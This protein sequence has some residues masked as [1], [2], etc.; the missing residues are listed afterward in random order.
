ML[1]AVTVILASCGS[2]GSASPTTVAATTATTS[3]AES[4][5]TTTIESTTTSSVPA[6]PVDVSVGDLP[7]SP[8]SAPL[9]DALTAVW[10]RTGDVWLVYYRG[11]TTDE[12]I[13]KCVGTSLA[14]A[15]GAQHVSHSPY[16]AL[17]CKGVAEEVLPPGS[18]H[19]CADRFVMAT[20]LIPT[21]KDGV[22]TATLDGTSADGSVEALTS[23]AD[24]DPNDVPEVDVSG[25]RVIS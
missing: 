24:A 25:C 19:L 1:V 18:L 7:P 11:L 23:G 8:V 3:V 22:L 10:Y 16:G 17:G 9:G 2:D 14:N 13:G 20:S 6:G 4:S 15:G 5:T 21:S 12:A